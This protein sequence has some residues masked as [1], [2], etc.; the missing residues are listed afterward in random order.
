MSKRKLDFANTSWESNDPNIKQKSIEYRSSK[1]R[2]VELRQGFKH[3]EWCKT[4]HVGYV[5]KGILEIKFTN[6]TVRYKEGDGIF[7]ASG[8][9]EKH[10]PKPISKKVT[11]FLIEDI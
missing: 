5:V 1:A 2:V 8:D 9:D 4:G 10:I 3:A 7:I 6:E 11:L